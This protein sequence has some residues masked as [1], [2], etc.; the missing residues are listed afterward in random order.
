MSP[1]ERRVVRFFVLLFAIIA[2]TIAHGFISGEIEFSMG[3]K[4]CVEDYCE[5]EQ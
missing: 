5:P 1:D 2:L 4:G 3:P